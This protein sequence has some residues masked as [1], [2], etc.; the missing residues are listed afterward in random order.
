MNNYTFL[1]KKLHTLSLKNNF[2]KKSLFE[3][4]KILFFNKNNMNDNDHIFITGLPRSGTTILLNFFNKSNK[5]ASLTYKDMPFV[6]SP[7]ILSKLTKND[8]IEPKER[9]H[10]DGIKYDQ[11][12]PDAFDEVFFLTFNED[13]YI[14]N[15]SKYIFLILK[16]YNKE[17]YLSKNNNNY[18]RIDFLKSKFTNSSIVIPFREPLQHTN[19]LLSQHIHFSK[20][21][22][23]DPFILDY[24]NYLG[25]FEFGLNHKSWFKSY[26]FNDLSDL[27]YWMEQW[28]FFYSS[29][30]EKYNSK[31]N[32]FFVSHENLCLNKDSKNIL[33]NK[34]NLKNNINFEFIYKKK[35]IKNKFDLNLISKCKEI[36]NKMNELSLV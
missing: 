5:Y 24:M 1:Q 33:I 13:S 18:K 19:S 14:E 25:H 29:L 36:Y 11:D 32:I 26:N 4:E 21:Q 15:Y 30:L 28:Y 8:K 9:I 17:N 34:F 22:Q 20:Q 7:N 35:E 6:M 16:K 27:N 12:S 31:K 2:I 10:K 23:K 3:I